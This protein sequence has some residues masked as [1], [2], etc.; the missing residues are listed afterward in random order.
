MTKNS[1]E[2]TK[3]IFDRVAEPTAT[4]VYEFA[5][6][7]WLGLSVQHRRLLDALQDGWLRPLPENKGLILGTADFVH[8][9]G[10]HS[11]LVHV[12]FDLEKLPV[13]DVCVLRDEQWL[14]CKL[15][16]AKSSDEMLYWPG[17][18]PTFAISILSVSSDEERRR[19]SGI[20]RQFSNVCLP[21]DVVV[22]PPKTRSSQLSS[23]PT[24]IETKI[25]I[26]PDEDGI[27][28]SMSMAVWAVPRIDPWMDVLVTSLTNDKAKL[29]ELASKVK[30]NWW[31]FPPWGSPTSDVTVENLQDG[32][33][34]A[35]IEVFR[36]HTG[37]SGVS[38]L[39]LAAQIKDITD[40]ALHTRVSKSETTAW[41]DETVRIL[42]AESS[43]RPDH[44]Q[45]YPVGMA[46]QLVLARPD[47]DN[48]KTW[49]KDIHEL[50]PGVW[51]SA[52]ALCGL[53]HGFKRLSLC[54]RGEL[55]LQE[56]LSVYALK[57]YTPASQNLHWP[58]MT[59]IPSWRRIDDGFVL[60]WGNKNLTRKPGQARGRWYAADFNNEKIRN[61]AMKL[62][63]DL[64]WPCLH[65]KVRLTTG[66]FPI[67]GP[68]EIE[69]LT[70]ELVIRGDINLLLPSNADIHTELDAKSFRDLVTVAAGKLPDPPKVVATVSRSI[71][72]TIPGLIY[73]RDFLSEK[74][75]VELVEK[76][77]Q[78][79]WLHDIKRRVQHYGW[80][81]DYVNRKID[82]GT[83]IDKLP[84]WALSLAQRLVEQELV[85][86]M[87]DQLIV[88]EYIR[89]QGIGKH[90]D[91]E[92]NFADGIAMISLLESWEM[93]FRKKNNSKIKHN[94]ML[95]NRSVAV[96]NGPARY[97]WT[98][99]IPS[100]KSEPGPETPDGK[101]PRKLR[102]RRL[103]LTFRKV[104]DEN[105]RR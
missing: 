96:M 35:A 21:V 84:E 50:P 73:V 4:R 47:P 10:K 98:H 102:K 92:P 95:E 38:P 25:E 28:G 3:L 49:H 68:G 36:N 88:N 54:F 16:D 86:Q 30:A 76:I 104:L 105:L 20:A 53:R 82:A 58:S 13:V 87:P 91:K 57:N 64:K 103:S 56:A 63:K 46:I 1:E 90:V 62:A 5:N 33:W 67:T 2:Q 8:E 101:V 69:I 61:T 44:W 32:L 41:Y 26:P 65:H 43:F 17:S 18:L 52:A 83:H 39:T 66:H 24:E 6:G 51:W 55:P 80:R 75:E 42:R 34:H 45:N 59:G 31:R 74:E 97:Q 89:D 27:R 72:H 11:I 99:E 19:L 94:V 71:D 79:S 85:P 22:G 100:R 14:H 23:E 40:E 29:A 78:N 70:R 77:D 9:A 81:Y 15:T 93:I 60:F 7:R 37:H 12:K 48:F